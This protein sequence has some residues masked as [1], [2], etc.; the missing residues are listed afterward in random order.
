MSEGSPCSDP[1]GLV[2]ITNA[3]LNTF[4]VVMLAL[5]AGWT[6]RNGNVHAPSLP[7]RRREP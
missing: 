3:I 6:R 5:I 1:A 4:Q 7:R 2:Q